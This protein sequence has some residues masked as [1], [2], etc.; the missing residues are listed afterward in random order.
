MIFNP[1]SCCRCGFVNEPVPR[2]ILRSQTSAG[3]AVPILSIADADQLFTHLRKFIEHIYFTYLAVNPRDRKVVIV[4]S[5]FCPTKFR[6]TL[7]KV[8]FTQFEVPGI[9]L[10]PGHLMSLNTV[11]ASTALVV[12]AGYTECSV[13]P[14]IEGVTV[15]DAAQFQSLGARTVHQ[16][17]RQELI[18]TKAP[19]S[20]FGQDYHFEKS[21]IDQLSESVIEDIKIRTCFVP[22]F[23]RGQQLVQA[24]IDSAPVTGSPPDVQY[25]LQG[26][27]VIS[28]PGIVRESAYQVLFEQVGNESTIAVMVLDAMLCTPI[29]CRRALASNILLI[30]GTGMAVG[31]RSRLS[32]ELRNLVAS[33]PEYESLTHVSEFKFHTPPCPVNYTSWL[34]SAI[35]ASTNAIG[36]KMITAK[37]FEQSRGLILSDWCNWWP[38]PRPA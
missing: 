35:Y 25:P 22:S 1:N 11:I 17:I 38:I 12:D 33:C 14:V 6:Q 26:Q 13:I 27:F 21:A 20:R 36:S 34:G 8:L 18:A 15:L 24:K 7:A 5:I 3:N 19:I 29:D 30:G 16:R 31:L 10:L 23:G 32:E 2:A 9:I 28:I 4:E 37:E